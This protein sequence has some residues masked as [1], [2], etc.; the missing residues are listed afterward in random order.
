MLHYVWMRWLNWWHTRWVPRETVDVLMEQMQASTR[1]VRETTELLRASGEQRE[2]LRDQ[3]E[4]RLLAL[5][6]ER[7]KIEDR[8]A[9]ETSRTWQLQ[10]KVQFLEG[11]LHRITT[12]AGDTDYLRDL[13]YMALD[14]KDPDAR[15]PVADHRQEA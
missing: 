11:W 4:G 10:T 12:A 14:G 2:Q 1:R 6:N 15:I 3:L 13:A 9:T 5:A 8:L 7:G